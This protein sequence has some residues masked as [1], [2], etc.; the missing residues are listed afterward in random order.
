[1]YRPDDQQVMRP[2]FLGFDEHVRLMSFVGY[3]LEWPRELDLDLAEEQCMR[4]A[5]GRLRTSIATRFMPTRR[6][7]NDSS[8]RGTF[9]CVI[10]NEIFQQTL[11]G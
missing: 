9:V 1:M 3:T 6:E 10:K 4:V 2:Y 7:G 11:Q 8:F 5:S